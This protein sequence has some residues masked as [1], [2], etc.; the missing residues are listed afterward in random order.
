MTMRACKWA[1][2]AYMLA[3]GT[4]MWPYGWSCGE[5]LVWCLATVGRGAGLVARTRVLTVQGRPLWVLRGAL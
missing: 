1:L 2:R 4:R 3:V 5:P